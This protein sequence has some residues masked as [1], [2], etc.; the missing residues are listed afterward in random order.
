MTAIGGKIILDY[1][2]IKPKWENKYLNSLLGYYSPSKISFVYKN[3]SSNTDYPRGSNMSFRKRIFDE[4]G[5]FNVEL[6]RQGNNLIGGEEKDMFQRIFSLKKHTV[7]YFPELIVYHSVPVERTTKEFIIRQA[8]DTGR[9]EMFRTK[10]NGKINYW[11]QLLSEL[12]KWIASLLLSIKFTIQGQPEKAR[13]L[14]VF[15]KYV[16]KGLFSK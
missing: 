6:G 10:A 8:Y 9:S 12:V 14:L 11:K 2:T 13:M 15:R 3:L 5:N 16:T 7:I 4:I 1:E